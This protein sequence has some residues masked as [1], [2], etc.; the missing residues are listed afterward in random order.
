MKCSYCGNNVPE[1]KK[2]CSSCGNPVSIEVNEKRVINSDES[3]NNNFS[4]LLS[5]VFIWMFI[6]LLV[7]FGVSFYVSQQANMLY[8]IFSRYYLFIVIAEFIVVIVLSRNI[9]KLSYLW[10]SIL[11]ILYSFL[12][13]LTFS[14]IFV[15]Y[16]L[17]SIGFLFGV[18]ALLFALLSFAGAKTK[19]DLTKFGTYLM[20][21]LLGIIIVSIINIFIGSDMI[22]LILSWIGIALFLG[23]TAFDVNNIKSLSNNSGIAKDNLAIYGAL[24]LYLDFINIFIRLLSLFGKNRD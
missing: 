10:A 22:T 11:F 8:N 19:I 9:H 24:Q 23:I 2:Y 1:N 12:T 14:S 20:V 5:K 4:Q 15:V 3:I 21:G 17:G 13:G 16:E 7:T 18:T 6:G